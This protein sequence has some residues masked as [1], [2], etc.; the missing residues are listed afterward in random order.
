MTDG[1]EGEW[2]SDRVINHALL[3]GCKSKWNY[4]HTANIKGAALHDIKHTVRQMFLGALDISVIASLDS[5]EWRAP[6][7]CR[8]VKAPTNGTRTTVLNFLLY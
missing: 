7:D 6:F 1:M 8:V 2:A 5:M 3:C 4:L